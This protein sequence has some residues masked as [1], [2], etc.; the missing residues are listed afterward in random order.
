MQSMVR[1][2]IQA[3]GP[4]GMAPDA[5]MKALDPPI[6]RSTLNRHLSALRASG[7]IKALGAGRA[8]RYVTTTP[9]TRADID[10]YFAVPVNTRPLAPF[11][12]ELLAPEPNIDPDRAARCARIQA[13]A[14]PM[15]AKYLST[16]LETFS[17]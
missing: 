7:V 11:R 2:L 8:T 15:D 4:A 16:F 10:G 12:E 9:F 13:L 1:D 14:Q 17:W 3:A 6:S 5:L